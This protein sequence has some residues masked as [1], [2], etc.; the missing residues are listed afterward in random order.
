[1]F[2]VREIKQ[3]LCC[4][5]SEVFFAPPFSMKQY[6]EIEISFIEGFVTIPDEKY[7]TEEENS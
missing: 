3:N 2:L 7:S 6:A 4:E 1:M 5:F